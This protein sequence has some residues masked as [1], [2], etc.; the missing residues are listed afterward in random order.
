M[1]FKFIHSKKGYGKTK[2]IFE[3]ISKSFENNII[4]FVPS[5]N[6]FMIENR[7]IDYFGEE[8]FSRVEVMDFKKLTSRL[9]N[10]Y[11]GF[12]TKRISDIGKIY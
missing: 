10:V 8:I 3:D 2:Y 4:I 1:K 6:T 7:L 5:H 12:K 11:K 9:L